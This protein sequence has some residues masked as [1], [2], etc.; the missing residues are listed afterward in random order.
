MAWHRDHTRAVP[1]HPRGTQHTPGATPQ[2]HPTHE[3]T[4]HPT[5]PED[6]AEGRCEVPRSMQVTRS[7]RTP[8]SLCCCLITSAVCGRG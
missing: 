8:A 4:P 3:H 7:T 2:H 6:G 1:G 5:N